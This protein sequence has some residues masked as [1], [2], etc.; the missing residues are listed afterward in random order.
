MRFMESFWSAL[1][2]TSTAVVMMA[3]IWFISLGFGV[4]YELLVGHVPEICKIGGQHG[5]E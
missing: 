1:K 4:T 5:A 2:A 3:L